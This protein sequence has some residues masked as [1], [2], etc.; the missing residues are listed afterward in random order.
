MSAPPS[1]IHH[2]ALFVRDLPAVERFYRDVLALPVLRRWP[3]ADGAGERSVWLD[4]GGGGFIALE[5]VPPGGAVTDDAGR[6]GWHLTAL[7]IDRAARADWVRRLTD[8]GFPVY[9]RTPYTIYT[10]DPEGNRVG[11]SHWPEAATDADDHV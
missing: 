3:A 2:I 8:A 9:H 5:V 1:G 6:P 4:L 10:R 11:L 7:R